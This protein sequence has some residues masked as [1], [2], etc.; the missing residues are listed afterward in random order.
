MLSVNGASVL[1]ITSE[2]PQ[3]A[4]GSEEPFVTRD[5][6]HQRWTTICDSA[7]LV[8]ISLPD[9]GEDYEPTRYEQLDGLLPR[10]SRIDWYAIREDDEDSMTLYRSSARAEVTVE[11]DARIVAVFRHVFGLDC[12]YVLRASEIDQ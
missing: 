6:W 9:D 1:A 3:K 4:G 5:Q 12:G 11:K 8:S 2:Q 10:L 7:G